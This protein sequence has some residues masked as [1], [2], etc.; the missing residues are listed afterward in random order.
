MDFE[1]ALFLRT[2]SRAWRLVRADTAPLILHVLGEIFIVGNVRTISEPDLLARID[3]LLYAV[4]ASMASDN[5]EPM[6]PR[7]ARAYL[8]TWADAGQGWL[9]KFYPEGSQEAHYDA[10]VD[11]EKAYA[12]VTGLA[13]RSFI[14]TQSRLQTIV[15]LLRDIVSGADADPGLR[16]KELHRRRDELDAQ[17]AAFNGGQRMDPVALLDRYQH[18]SSTARELLSDFRA[19]EENFRVLDR[20]IRADIF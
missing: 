19:V 2:N 13:V 15:E 20:Q 4:N 12:F 10:T 7:T 17:I 11:L 18:F 3:D 8:D 5:G 6:Y 9:R 14:G 16:L 1:T